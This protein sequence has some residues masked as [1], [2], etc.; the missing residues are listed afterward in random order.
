[1]LEVDEIPKKPAVQRILATSKQR[2]LEYDRKRRRGNGEYDALKDRHLEGFLMRRGIKHNI[3][4]RRQ[5]GPDSNIRS[6]AGRPE[7]NSQIPRINK[8]KFQGSRN[9]YQDQYQSRPQTLA[10]PISR[11]GNSNTIITNRNGVIIC[12]KCQKPKAIEGYHPYRVI[13]PENC[14]IC[15][16]PRFDSQSRNFDSTT[17]SVFSDFSDD[18]DVENLEL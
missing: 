5:P 8:H 3:K 4:S 12:N 1:M 7:S 2:A 6:P 11:S 10:N 15:Q 16:K 18:I 14:K 9:R 17:I 13:M